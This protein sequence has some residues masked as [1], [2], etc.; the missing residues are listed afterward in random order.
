MYKGKLR[1]LS[2]V[3]YVSTWDY[4][5]DR[6]FEMRASFEKEICGD[7]RAMIWRR[8]GDNQKGF[9]PFVDAVRERSYLSG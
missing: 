7:Y 1:S 8:C 5:A 6:V 3:L 4:V 2:I 9:Y